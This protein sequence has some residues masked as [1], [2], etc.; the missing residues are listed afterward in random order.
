[1]FY[2]LAARRRSR[3]TLERG[4]PALGR[5]IRSVVP[6][7]PH[8]ERFAL[9]RLLAEDANAWGADPARPKWPVRRRA[10]LPTVRKA[11]IP[12]LTGGGQ[13]GT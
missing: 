2:V 3:E 4:L 1:M 9:T 6:T 13:E 10:A 12:G 8:L 5:F 7:R 11:A